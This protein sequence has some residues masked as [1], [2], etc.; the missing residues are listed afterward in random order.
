M[1]DYLPKVSAVLLIDWQVCQGVFDPCSW[2]FDV[3]S[4]DHISFSQNKNQDQAR[5]HKKK[6]DPSGET[7]MP[8]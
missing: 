4:V 6:G 2:G 3:Y 1:M 7:I 5:S 8:S